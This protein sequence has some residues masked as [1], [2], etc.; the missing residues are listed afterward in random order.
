MI[1]RP[2]ES[3]TIPSKKGFYIVRGM[4]KKGSVKS[5]SFFETD[6]YINKNL[7]SDE[8][9]NECN[10]QLDEGFRLS[11]KRKKTETEDEFNKRCLNKTMFRYFFHHYK[12][13]DW[14]DNSFVLK[15]KENV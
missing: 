4:L 11:K 2:L 8:K 15:M 9:W 5:K 13:Y 14:V 3:P 10:K 6:F 1:I 7:S 12:E